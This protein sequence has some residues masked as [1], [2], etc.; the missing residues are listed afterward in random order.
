MLAFGDTWDH[1]LSG[2]VTVV[3]FWS[4]HGLSQPVL[5]PFAYH[6]CVPTIILFNHA[7]LLISY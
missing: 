2:L 4:E 7:E 6:F 1:G 5:D 3:V